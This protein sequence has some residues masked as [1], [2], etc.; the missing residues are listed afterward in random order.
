MKTMI[1]IRILYPDKLILQ[2]EKLQ[3]FFRPVQ[4]LICRSR[5]ICADYDAISMENLS[6]HSEMS[7]LFGGRRILINSKLISSIIC[8][9]SCI[10][11]ILDNVKKIEEY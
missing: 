8:T 6:V 1:H 3:Y 11:N 7:L 4:L 2:E 10:L 9:T 5:R